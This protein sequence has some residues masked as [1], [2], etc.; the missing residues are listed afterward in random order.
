LHAGTLVIRL[1]MR[2]RPR[3]PALL[4]RRCG[5]AGQKRGGPGRGPR[6][7][8]GEAPPV[9]RDP[10]PDRRG[11]TRPVAAERGDPSA[12]QPRTS[13]RGSTPPP[14]PS[15][16]VRAPLLR[17]RLVHGQTAVRLGNGPRRL[18]ESRSAAGHASGSLA[19]PR[20]R[21][22]AAGGDDPGGLSSAHRHRCGASTSGGATPGGVIEALAGHAAAS[23]PTPAIQLRGFW[24]R[25]PRRGDRTAGSGAA[26]RADEAPNPQGGQR[27]VE[28]ALRQ[29]PALPARD[30]AFRSAG[31]Q[32][33]RSGVGPDPDFRVPAGLA[34]D[35]QGAPAD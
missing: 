17:L 1:P 33:R 13:P 8:A 29:F 28:A 24:H 7:T 18:V 3:L 30:P 21:S 5:V 34:D 9:R 25:A 20:L 10:W 31:F 22:R 14:R 2:G 35:D 32:P 6:P 15:I 12:D 16:S 27:P 11:K 26:E 4:R 23:P 19:V